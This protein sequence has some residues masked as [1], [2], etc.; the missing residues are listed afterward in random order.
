[1]GAD[2]EKF[3]ATKT[4]LD[5][6]AADLIGEAVPEPGVEIYCVNCG[7]RGSIK[8]TGSISATPLRVV[9]SASIGVSGD[10][11]IGMYI[12][13]NAYAKWEKEWEKEIFSKGLPG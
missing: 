3:S 1:M 10:M 13:V 11:Y 9:K 4:V 7:V 2:D 12:G 5:N 8:A 6:L